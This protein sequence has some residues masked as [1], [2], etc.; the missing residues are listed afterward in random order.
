[1]SFDDLLAQDAAIFTDADASAE[2]ES[3]EFTPHGGTARTMSVQVF[4]NSPAEVEGR[5][6]IGTQIFMQRHATLGALTI[7]PGGDRVKIAKRRGGTAEL[8]KVV[9][10]LS[11]DAGGFML[12]LE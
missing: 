10:I 4:R 12:H 3:V 7:N 8:H 2:V 5:V 9:A 11:E 1:M 6:L